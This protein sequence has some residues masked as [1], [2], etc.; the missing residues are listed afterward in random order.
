[1]GWGSINIMIEDDRYVFKIENPPYGLQLEADNWSF[2]S[3]MILGYL[4]LIDN[5]FRLSEQ[6]GCYKRL[7][8]VY[9]VEE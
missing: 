4:W 8:I 1:M 3:E 6:R 2:L 5:N 7:D 9:E